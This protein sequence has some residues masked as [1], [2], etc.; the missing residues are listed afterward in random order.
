MG[1]KL[2]EKEFVLKAKEVHGD[3]YDYSKV[4]Y[5]GCRNEV[6]IV[7]SE[8]GE[9]RQMPYKHLQSKG[10]P[11]CG[12][13]TV[14]KKLSLN[15][16][17]FIE[18]AKKIHGDKYDYS[19]VEYINNKTKV[20]IIC[21]EHGEFWQTPQAHLQGEG[22]LIC[23][24][25]F[26]FDTEE[27]IKRAREVHGNKYDYSKV[28]YVDAHTPVCIICYEHGEFWQKPY[29]HLQNHGCPI[30]KES[31]LENEIHNFLCENKIKFNEQQ[32]FNWLG[33]QS[34]DF[35]LPD[36]NVAIECQGEQHFN[37][38]CF[39]HDDIKGNEKIRKMDKIK[40]EKCKNNKLKLL[41]YSNLKINYPY[42]VIEDKNKLLEEIYNNI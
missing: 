6:V 26:K 3:K 34:L 8:H 11:K 20:C 10:C 36:Y 2:S 32:K 37:N 15:R 5:T 4:N 31:K 38:R 29:V 27:F 25:K 19:K 9:F 33:R 39:G 18:K 22:C 21:P 16:E 28:E 13:L 1:H 12:Y 41:Y 30:C 14:Q 42:Y 7:C 35:Y 24:G 40:F 23:C 17:E